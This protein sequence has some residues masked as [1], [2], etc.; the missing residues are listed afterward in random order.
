MSETTEKTANRGESQYYRSD[1]W[2]IPLWSFASGVNNL[3]V[4]VM[5]FASYAAAGGYGIAVAM[6]GLIATSSRM[7]DAVTDP[8]LALISDR[9]KSRF[10]KV[11]ILMGIGY[12][13]MCLAVSTIFFFGVGTNIVVYTFSYMVY[14]IGY[15]LFGVGRGMGDNVITNDPIQRS[16]VFRFNNIYTTTL[17]VL[18]TSYLSMVLAPKYKGL[19]MGA[20]QEMAGLGMIA[21]TILLI[22]AM[23]GITPQDKM[24]NFTGK[25]KDPI[26]LHDCWNLLK[27]NRPIW[28]YIVAVSSDKLA[29]QAAGQAAVTT[30]L[31]G[32]VIGNYAFQG[33]QNLITLVPTILL[34][35][36][37]TRMA[38]R[39][40]A[41]SALIKWTWAAIVT[42]V[43]FAAF[44]CLG[45]PRKI[46][47]SP[48]V[49]ALFIILNCLLT[50]TKVGTTACIGVMLPDIIDYELYR[51]GN[52]MPA[53][54]TAVYS[55]VDK[56]ISS[57]AT[58]IVAL[59]VAAIGYTSKMPQPSDTSTPAIFWMTM[60]LWL[61]LPVI[62]WLCTIV[63]MKFYPL[64]GEKMREIQISNKAARDAV[65]GVAS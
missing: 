39:T 56:L 38:G 14:I 32:I 61:G 49:T 8:I 41:K 9:I 3:F 29:L 15:T 18:L 11:R 42:S 21:G 46:S 6:A 31:F 22:L 34:I 23:I 40:G 57:L 59:C 51:S 58:T 12:I 26:K 36:L 44:M 45:D 30:M 35:F 28:L 25:R 13:I 63:A 7:F 60:F 10:G 33:S 48:I 43:V 55:F 27:G 19:A 37:I 47:V 52:F 16:K 1:P 4:M 64:D 24:K 54:I 53:T 5:M 20:F 2:R 65:A 62:G 50:G 17:T